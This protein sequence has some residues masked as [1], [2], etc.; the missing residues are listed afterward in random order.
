MEQ[1]IHPCVAKFVPK[2]C[3][4]LYKKGVRSISRL[5]IDEPETESYQVLIVAMT[6]YLHFG[7]N[8]IKKNNS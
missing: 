3:K 8:G 5:H 6:D 1:N 4:N 2:A 7:Y